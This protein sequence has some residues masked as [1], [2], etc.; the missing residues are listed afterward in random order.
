MENKIQNELT[1]SL[2][3][4]IKISEK[5]IVTL[6]ADNRAIIETQIELNKEIEKAQLV[7]QKLHNDRK[8]IDLKLKNNRDK[9][10]T[11][12]TGLNSKHKMLA[13]LR[14][15]DSSNITSTPVKYSNNTTMTKSASCNTFL[16]QQSFNTSIL[17]QSN[18]TDIIEHLNLKEFFSDDLSKTNKNDQEDPLTIGKDAIVNVNNIEDNQNTSAIEEKDDDKSDSNNKQNQLKNDELQQEKNDPIE[19]EQVASI[20]EIDNNNN[21]VIKPSNS[22]GKLNLITDKVKTIKPS[23]GDEPNNIGDNKNFNKKQ[24]K[25]PSPEEQSSL[26]D[27]S[28]PNKKLLKPSANDENDNPN[29][30]APKPSAN[31]ENDN[32]NKIGQKTKPDKPV[33]VNIGSNNIEDKI[34]KRN[35][36]EPASNNAKKTK[37]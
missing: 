25:P 14:K 34:G 23:T 2:C 5:E 11:I 20:G 24:T 8:Q 27:N 29:K 10:L 37:L 15:T 9:I 36:N 13:L 12:R 35:A 21:N 19:Q 1:E 28:N 6:T 33:V 32:P 18:A 30:K 3:H 4:E 22:D 26:G 7:V 16:S 17:N 31:D